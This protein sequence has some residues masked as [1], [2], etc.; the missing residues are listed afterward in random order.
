MKDAQQNILIF[1]NTEET[2]QIKSII[3]KNVKK[4]QDEI[5]KRQVAGKI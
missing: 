5:R 2:A 3:L 1:I 4:R